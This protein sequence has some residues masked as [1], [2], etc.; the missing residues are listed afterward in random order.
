[1]TL[2]IHTTDEVYV[3]RAPQRTRFEADSSL[4]QLLESFELIGI[5]ATILGLPVVEG[6]VAD[7]MFPADIDHFTALLLLLEDADDLLLCES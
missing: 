2:T 3:H 6:R 4:L 7:P 1:M 5:H